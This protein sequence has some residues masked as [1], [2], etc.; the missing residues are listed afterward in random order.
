VTKWFERRSG[1][2]LELIASGQYL[3]GAVW[4]AVFEQLIAA[5]GW[6]QTMLGFGCLVLLVVVPLSLLYLKPA[7]PIEDANA[8]AIEASG[9]DTIFGLR[10]GVAFSL[11]AGASFL[12]C[13]PMAIP[14]AHLIAFCGD[15]GIAPA[16][17][18]LLLSFL[19]TCAFIS[20]QLWG[21]LSD[22]IGGLRTLLLSSA[23]QAIGVSGLLFTQDEAGLIAVAVIFG[24]GFSGLIPAY[25]LT[26]RQFFPAREASW[27]VPTL[28]LTGMSGMAA[29]GWLAGVL[30]DYFGFYAPAFATGLAFNLVNFVILA[31]LLVKWRRARVAVAAF[32]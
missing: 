10:P 19:L 12:C 3:S 27:R 32:A 26:I 17:S 11:L 4:P 21:W 6:L 13:V 30:Y 23:A 18:A 28:L 25:V 9:R 29:G 5:V 8:A 16:R 14:P 20:R 1:T 2:A 15:L 31:S 7:P 22:R 24:F